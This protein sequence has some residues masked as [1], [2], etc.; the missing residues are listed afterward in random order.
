MLSAKD[1]LKAMKM[2]D[3]SPIHNR[4]S[5]APMLQWTDEHWRYF[6]SLITKKTLLYTEMINDHAIVYNPQKIENYLGI[7]SN[8]SV[9]RVAIQLGGNDPELL[10]DAAYLCS[11]FGNYSE[12]NLNAGCPSN[13]A[14]RC[15]YG[16]EL[17]LYPE[18]VREILY[19][20]RRKCSTLPI[21]VKCRIGVTN[22]ES[23]EDLVEFVHQVSQSGVRKIIIHSRI[24]VLRGLSPAQNRNIP[25]LKYDIVHKI[26]RQFPEMEVVLNGGIESFD[27]ANFHMGLNQ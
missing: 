21:S 20:M 22:R 17:M 15:G 1:I 10:S 6:A 12:I 16:A 5:V 3:H 14:K 23:Y 18:K 9:D 2:T 27:A 4:F 26:A 25:P 19:A 7:Q 24:C 13:K 11:S 8:V